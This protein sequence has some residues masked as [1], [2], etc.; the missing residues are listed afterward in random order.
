MKIFVR[1]FVFY[2]KY[3]Y[4]WFYKIIR[5]KKILMY[6]LNFYN[7]THKVWYRINSYL[8]VP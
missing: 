5:K 7:Y 4:N 1:V 6:L 8:G 3:N 2:T